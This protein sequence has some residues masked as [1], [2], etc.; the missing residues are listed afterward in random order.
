M[1]TLPRTSLVVGL[2]AVAAILLLVLSSRGSTSPGHPDADGEL[3]VTLA[4]RDF[5]PSHLYLPTG[6]P[7][8]LRMVNESDV[9]HVVA[10]GRETVEEGGHPAAPQ[11]DMLEGVAV[12][13]APGSAL[14]PPTDDDPYTGIRVETGEE[15]TV[16]FTLPEDRAG[17]WELGCFTASGCYYEIGFRADVTVE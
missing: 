14:Q 12:T 13:T 8:T 1:K 9:G 17:E 3:D 10:F 7:L 15:V 11:V 6:E 2:V 5:E 4:I 16:Q